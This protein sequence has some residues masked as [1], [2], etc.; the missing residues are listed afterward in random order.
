MRRRFT[1][2]DDVSLRRRAG[3]VLRHRRPQRLG[4]EHAAQVHGRDLQGRRG[5]RSA[6]TAAC[7][8]SS[9]SASA[10]TRTSPRATTR[11]STR[12]CSGSRAREARER[13]ERDHRLRRA[14][15]VRGA[16][17]QELLVGH[18]RAARVLGDDPG[19][20]RRAADRRG[21]RGRRRRLPAEVLRRV[22]PPARRGPH[23]PARHARHERGRALLRPRDAARARR[24]G[25]HRRP[26]RGRE[27]VLRDRTSAATAATAPTERGR[28]PRLGD[29]SA[30]RSPTP[31]SRTATAT[32]S[33]RSR[34]AP[35]ARSCARRALRRAASTDPVFGVLARD[36]RR[37][38]RCSRPRRCGTRS[39]PAR[40]AAGE[41][42][43]FRVAFDNYFA[44]GP[45]LTRRRGSRAAARA[46]TCI[47]RVGRHGLRR[48]DR[49]RAPA[50]ASSTSRTTLRIERARWRSRRERR[51]DRARRCGRA[52]AGPSALGG[53]PRRFWT[54][55][56][57]LAVLEFRLQVLRLGA[58]LLLAADAAAAAVRRP[59]LRLHAV[60]AAR[61]RRPVLPGRC[62]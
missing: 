15:R 40:F 41:H 47:D 59:L 9:S 45:L 10:S 62:C 35:R 20:R 38:H 2:L 57:T 48:G 56:W 18:A 23:D 7:R 4:Q 29:G 24:G 1:A 50:A 46:R 31:G 34:R 14:A 21:A 37:Q 22:Q 44:P 51:C 27:R 52:C 53:D 16:Q 36:R 58:R 60:R 55:T 49:R 33:T 3:R 32:A 39:T 28:R 13:Y 30:S 12:S 19:R 11:S 17:A 42:V 26:R 6:S 25:R 54:L 43:G 5:R 8:R 61:R